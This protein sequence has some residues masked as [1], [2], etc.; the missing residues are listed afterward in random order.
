MFHYPPS[1]LILWGC[2]PVL[3]PKNA[4]IHRNLPQIV[5]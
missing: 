2:G 4:V 1:L 3:L 5:A